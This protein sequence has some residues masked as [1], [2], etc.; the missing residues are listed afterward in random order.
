MRAIVS[1][2][3]GWGIGRHNGLVVPNASDLH[4]FRELTLGGTVICGRKT[5]EGLPKRPLDGRRNIV[6][7]ANEGF[8][9][10]GAEVAR[11]VEGV[12]QMVGKEDPQEVWVIGGAKVYEQLLPHCD[13]ALVTWHECERDADAFFPDLDALDDWVL[14]EEVPGGVTDEGVPYG[15][16]T[17]A[18]LGNHPS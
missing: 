9:A 2:T 16:R 7:S 6:L 8:S 1:V 5:Y 13:H 3:R 11:S 14:C 17:Y 18:S 4:R 10:R 15:Y 12:L